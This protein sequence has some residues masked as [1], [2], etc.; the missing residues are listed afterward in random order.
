MTKRRPLNLR[1]AVASVILLLAACNNVHSAEATAAATVADPHLESVKEIYAWVDAAEGGF[2]TPKQSVR[3]MIEHDL[4]TPLIVY[5]TEDIAKGELLVQTPWSHILQSV[6]EGK[7]EASD[8]YCGTSMKLAKEMRLGRDSFYA[9][10]A[11]YINEEPDG[12]LPAQYSKAAKEMLHQIIGRHPDE[13][14]RSQ[15]FE[16]GESYDQRIM[17]ERITEGLE[18]SWYG[19]CRMPRSDVISAK[20][21]SMVI[22]R[23]DDDIL[24]PA[25][26]AYNHRNN[27]KHNGVEYMNAHAKTTRN[28][29]H[30]TFALRDISKGEQIFIS[31]NQCPQCGGRADY[32]F[33]TAEMYR[34]YGFVEWFPQRWCVHFC[35]GLVLALRF[36][37]RLPIEFAFIFLNLT[38]RFYYFPLR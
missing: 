29:H 26:D 32:G 10:Y 24:I 14:N 27:D 21:A 19:A 22:Q 3:R 36:A 11:V 2:V 34:E 1:A 12:Q 7:D 23:A 37:S 8:W 6:D 20:A 17:P 38:L 5:A 25:Y 35:V 16:R 4:D 30:Q 15:I 9:P 31:Y 33:G 28:K 18:T 13:I